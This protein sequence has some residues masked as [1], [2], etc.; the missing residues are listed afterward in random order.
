MVENSIVSEAELLNGLR[1]R[2]P[3]FTDDRTEGSA[4]LQE[5][6]HAFRAA[7]QKRTDLAV[8]NHTLNLFLEPR[9]P[10]EPGRARKPKMEAIVFGTLIALVATAVLAFNLAAPRP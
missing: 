8:V 7:R 1:R 9:N 5:V 4:T 3:V 10:F 2:E 6:D